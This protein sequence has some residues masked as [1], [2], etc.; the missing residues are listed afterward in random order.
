MTIEIIFLIVLVVFDTILALILV[1]YLLR[2]LL[3]HL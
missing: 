1:F 2:R 3:D